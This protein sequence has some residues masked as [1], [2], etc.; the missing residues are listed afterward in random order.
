[1]ACHWLEPENVNEDDWQEA[2]V[3]GLLGAGSEYEVRGDE[4]AR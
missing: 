2:T 3:S 4:W 1:M